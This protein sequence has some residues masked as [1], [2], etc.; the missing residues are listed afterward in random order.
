LDWNFLQAVR[1]FKEHFGKYWN[2]QKFYGFLRI[3]G[4]FRILKGI[5]GVLEV[6]R[7][8]SFQGIFRISDFF[9]KISFL[10]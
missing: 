10:Q 8:I 1:T 9:W 3:L 2:F 7:P 5:S 6:I 4:I